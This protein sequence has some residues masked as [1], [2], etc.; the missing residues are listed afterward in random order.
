MRKR[1]V[2]SASAKFPF[3]GNRRIC[4]FTFPHCT[5]FSQTSRRRENTGRLALGKFP[6]NKYCRKFTILLKNRSTRSLEPVKKRVV[7]SKIFSFCLRTTKIF[8]ENLHPLTFLTGSIFRAVEA[9]PRN[10]GIRKLRRFPVSR[11]N[12]LARKNTPLCHQISG[13]CHK[14]LES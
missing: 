3:L 12:I 11:N 7:F 1:D 14:I 5:H 10:S 13:F 2:R 4:F 9:L 6:A 8:C